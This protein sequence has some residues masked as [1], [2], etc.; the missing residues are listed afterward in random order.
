MAISANPDEVNKSV[1]LM[2]DA[3]HSLAEISKNILG[4]RD[5][6]NAITGHTMDVTGYDVAESNALREA[7]NSKI[8]LLEGDIAKIKSRNEASTMT[9]RDF[10]NELEGGD[11]ENSDVMSKVEAVY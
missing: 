1:N 11:L 5:N 10:F 9:L 4:E 3:T 7:L 2:E 8:E 6:I